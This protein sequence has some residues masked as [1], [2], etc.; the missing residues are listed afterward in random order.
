M[1]VVERR[2]RHEGREVVHL[3]TYE[4]G[5][6]EEEEK[7]ESVGV[8]EVVEWRAWRAAGRETYDMAVGEREVKG[9]RE[10]EG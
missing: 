1:E 7:Q 5:T 3:T 2:E 8:G 4:R 10:I 6:E 9:R